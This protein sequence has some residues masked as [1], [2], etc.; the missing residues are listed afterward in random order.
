WVAIWASHIGSL[1]CYV[2]A[3]ACPL[4]PCSSMPVSV[5]AGSN[6]CLTQRRHSIRGW[7]CHRK[8]LWDMCFKRWIVLAVVLS[9]TYPAGAQTAVD[10][11]VERL[12]ETAVEDRAEDFDLSGLADRLY[13]YQKHPIDLNE[14]DGS[15]LK[16][17]GFVPQLFID[18]LLDHRHRSGAF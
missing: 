9:T 13:Y 12:A 15:E 7:A 3:V 4:I 10:L 14:T 17:L 2:C 6:L 8:S 16:E 5:C 18:N 1:T 11:L